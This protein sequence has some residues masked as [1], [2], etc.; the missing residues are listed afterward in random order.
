MK[1][2]TENGRYSRT[3]SRPTFSPRLVQMF[4]R[5]VRGLGA[6]THH[7][8]HALGIGRAD[9]IEQVIGAAD[10]LG[11]LVHRR[12]HLVGAGV[13]ERIDGFARLEINVGILR[14]AAQA[15]DDRETARAAD[16]RRRDPC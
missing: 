5:L 13:V 11:K 8:D 12:L 1:C 9:V 10:D 7:D 6:R 2:L 4:D 16:A 15:P 14:G 3:F